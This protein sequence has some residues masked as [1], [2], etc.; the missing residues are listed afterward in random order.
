MA[1]NR[2]APEMV[3]NRHTNN[4]GTEFDSMADLLT[5]GSL[6]CAL[7]AP[8]VSEGVRMAAGDVAGVRVDCEFAREQK[9]Y[10]RS[11]EFARV[12]GA[13]A[14]Q[15]SVARDTNASRVILYFL[16]EFADFV[17]R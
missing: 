13:R 6:S 8:I 17:A 2:G 3:V 11:K 9:I 7:A 12:V 4:K 1:E 15:E 14:W 5:C 10:A 16:L